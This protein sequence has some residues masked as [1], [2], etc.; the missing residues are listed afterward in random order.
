MDQPTT[1]GDAAA[2]AAAAAANSTVDGRFRV[3]CDVR[4]VGADD[5]GRYELYVSDPHH[6]FVGK[7][8]MTL[9]VRAAPKVE[10]LEDGGGRAQKEEER[11]ADQ[12]KGKEG[13]GRSGRLLSHMDKAV[14][15]RCRVTAYPL[16]EVTVRA[17]FRGCDDADCS[18]LADADDGRRLAHRVEETDG[19]SYAEIA[20]PTGEVGR[21]SGLV[22]CSACSNREGLGCG[23]D[24]APLL[25]TDLEE[26]IVT[27]QRKGG[28]PEE[29]EGEEE[30]GGPV[31][32]YC[33]GARQLFASLSWW[34]RR[35]GDPKGEFH[36]MGSEAG[37][38]EAV[39]TK[40][41][42]TWARIESNLTF[43]SFGPSLNGA[44]R[45]VGES[46]A[47]AAAPWALRTWLEE[48]RFKTKSVEKLSARIPTKPTITGSSFRDGSTIKLDPRENETLFC[49]A[50]GFPTPT[51]T[52]LKDNEEI[53][54]GDDFSVSPD[55]T[56][57]TIEK[58][59]DRH[60][61]G[62]YACRAENRLGEDENTVEVEVEKK[63]K[64]LKILLPI[65]VGIFV[66]V[67]ALIVVYYRRKVRRAKKRLPKKD[68]EKLKAG[69]P[70]ALKQLREQEQRDQEEGGTGGG[71]EGEDATARL[72]A[73]KPDA[74]EKALMLPYD[75]ERLE[76][77]FEKLSL[78]S[79]VIL[80]F[81]S[82]LTSWNV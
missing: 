54:V 11:D 49:S 55:G 31:S 10:I 27:A 39:R 44:Y 46:R 69:D 21:Q 53:V 34:R 75:E 60:T 15:T 41:G 63:S 36:P 8:D 64:L 25:T 71:A 80:S 22:V 23:E 43:E 13:G 51:M 3:Y 72:V 24:E 79:Q 28:D 19:I 32:L 58:G 52:W 1:N 2:A 14:D 45:C 62:T 38:K 5:M 50:E 70:D 42:L 81:S 33:A 37:E 26:T 61:K 74:G 35:P 59:A 66:K 7:I 29:E 68:V 65:L 57:L 48:T 40:N 16:E 56:R 18:R 73:G 30:E 82:G 17:A 9:Y 78:G 6:A 20:I 47:E 67:I 12:R 76:F 4:D 77:P